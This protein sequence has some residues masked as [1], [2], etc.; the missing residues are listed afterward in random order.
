MTDKNNAK[1]KQLLNEGYMLIHNTFYTYLPM[2]ATVFILSHNDQ[3]NA[4]FWIV[5]G[6]SNNEILLS[7]KPDSKNTTTIN[8]SQIIQ[9]WKQYDADCM[10][11]LRLI[12]N[13]LTDKQARITQLE[14]Q[15][16]DL[17]VRLEELEK[18]KS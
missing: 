4:K 6:H 14:S 2:F 5:R 18:I 3:F 16:R 9:L 10:I 1:I 12:Y 11:E 13:S 7:E 15:V 17:S 8:Y